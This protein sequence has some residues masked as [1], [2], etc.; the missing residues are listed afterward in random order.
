MRL[1]AG[2]SADREP[3]YGEVHTLVHDSRGYQSA[4]PYDLV[5]NPTGVRR[6]IAAH[7]CETR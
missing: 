1:P 3:G 5:L 4:L 6:C 2:W 7:Q